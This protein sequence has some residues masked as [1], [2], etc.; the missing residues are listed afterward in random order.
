MRQTTKKIVVVG[1]GYVGLPLALAFGEKFDT[2]GFDISKERIETLKRKKDINIE[3]S[4]RDF[5]KSKLI[6]F[7]SNEKDLLDRNIFIISVPTPIYSNKKLDIRNIVNATKTVTKYIK[8]NAYVIYESTVYPGFTED[9]CLPIL[10]QKGIKYNTDFYIG[11]SPERIN[12]GDKK[13]TLKKIVKITSGSNKKSTIFIDKLYKEIIEAGTHRVSNIKIAEAAKVIENAQRDVNIAF[14]NELTKI[15]DKTNIDT[16]EV[17]KAAN[18]KWNF[19]D[20]KPGFVGGHCIGV[21]PYYLNYLAEKNKIETKIILNGRNVNDSMA[22][23]TAKKIHKILKANNKNIKNTKILLLGYTFKEN[24]ND[25]R[26][27]M[28]K[29]IYKILKKKTNDIHIS[30]PY[31]SKDIKINGLKFIETK[32]IKYLDYGLIAILVKHDYFKN[33]KINN[34]LNNNIII[35]DFH[36]F[37]KIKKTYKF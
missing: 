9:V 8:K 34:L 18:T 10:K 23:Y 13:H 24:C 33:L 28:T 2:L 15:F 5:N 36:D 25:Y 26:N 31:L 27:T 22:D 19:L 16:G 3:V 37:L 4:E 6:N 20:F 7:S 14:V 17:L 12:P 21:D 11:Y 35:Y 29:N 30:D 32:K 1:L